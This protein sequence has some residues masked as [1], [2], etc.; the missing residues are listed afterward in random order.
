V[1]LDHYRLEKEPFS[2]SPDPEFLWLSEKHAGGFN[3]LKEGILNR[4]GCA[5]LT[6]DIG[7]GK[8]TLVK[9]LIQLE[10]VA[11]IWVTI[12]DNDLTRLEFCNSLAVEFGINRRFDRR[13]DFYTNLKHVLLG[14]FSA[15]TKVIVVIDEA[16]RLNP[17]IIQEAVELSNLQLAGQKPLKVFF[18]GLLDFDQLLKQDENRGLLRIITARYDMEPLAEKETRRYVDHRLKVAGRDIPLFTED[19]LKEVHALSKGYPRLINIV[20][21]HALLCGFSS[22]LNEIDSRVIRECSQDLTVALDLDADPDKNVPVSSTEGTVVAP[23]QQASATVVRSWRPFLY[24][25][26]AVALVGM[27]VFA[28][29]H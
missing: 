28:M 9:R 29:T 19:A 23:H 17:E 4:D 26:A 16:Q 1:Y 7:T 22:G 8:T 3:T 11:A 14:K 20:C 5:L 21:D 13:E 24:I 6:G 27:A 15:C 12:N 2:I 25:A 18:V 10:G